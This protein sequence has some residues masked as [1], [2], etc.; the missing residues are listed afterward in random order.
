[1]RSP[2]AYGYLRDPHMHTGIDID[3]RMH[4]GIA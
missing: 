3:P 1:M 4:M 2:Y